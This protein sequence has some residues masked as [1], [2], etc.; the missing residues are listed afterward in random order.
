MESWVPPSRLRAQRERLEGFRRVRSTSSLAA[1]VA[2]LLVL[3]VPSRVA[4]LALAALL[5]SVLLLEVLVLRLQ[6]LA[7][8]SPGVVQPTWERVGL[9]AFL[10]AALLLGL[11]LA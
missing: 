11:L 3:I 8:P 2:A 7:P 10:E 6:G 1:G 5:L 4:L 9:L